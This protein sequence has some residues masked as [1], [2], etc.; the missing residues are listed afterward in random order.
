M[1]SLSGE[2]LRDDLSCGQ[3]SVPMGQGHRLSSGDNFGDSVSSHHCVYCN[4][5]FVENWTLK[6]HMR[7]HTGEKPYECELCG[8]R[9][10]QKSNLANH[11]WN[12]HEKFK[13]SS[14]DIYK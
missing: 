7:V 13:H 1:L 3:S 6:R 11:K 9:C 4:K 12:R 8:F 5:F 10:T 2:I 14:L